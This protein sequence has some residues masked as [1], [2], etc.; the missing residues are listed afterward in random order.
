MLIVVIITLI[1]QQRNYP[2][3]RENCT[4]QN[5]SYFLPAILGRIERR[6]AWIIE[7]RRQNLLKIP[8]TFKKAG[9]KT[10]K[11]LT[12]LPN[13]KVDGLRLFNPHQIIIRK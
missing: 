2:G 5:S 13:F 12:L 7:R 4:K 11:T 10:C 8:V 3:C 6:Q 9:L 1:L